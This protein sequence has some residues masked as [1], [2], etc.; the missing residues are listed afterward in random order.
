M[1][2]RAW[3]SG[4]V[5]GVSLSIMGHPFDTIKTRMQTNPSHRS[6]FACATTLARQEG[7]LSLWKGISPAIAAG[8]MTG[9]IR[10]G[11]QS[12][13]NRTLA[14]KMG[15]RD[16]ADLNLGTRV[17]S[18][19]LGGVAAGMVLPILFTPL[20]M[21]KCRQQVNVVANTK[22]LGTLHILRGVLRQEGLRGLYVGHVMTTLRST[23]G[24]AALFGSYVL[25]KEGLGELLG[26]ESAVVQPLSGIIAGWC[27]WIVCFPVDAIK[28]RMQ[29]AEGQM[30]TTTTAAVP[31]QMKN[32]RGMAVHE[33]L[34]QLWREGGMYRGMGPVLARAVPVH[35]AYLPVFDAVSSVLRYRNL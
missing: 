26:Y 1:D 32:L 14:W 25:A 33:A 35:M 11:V 18:E 21:V 27:S 6:A 4:G 20:E 7:V 13:A 5:A 29:V 17:V 22:P 3:V 16:F 23:F 30:K 34:R 8:V 31:P 19:S 24:N 28:T 2:W 15:A 9:S 10:F 12:W